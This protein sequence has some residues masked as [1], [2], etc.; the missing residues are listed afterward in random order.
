MKVKELITTINSIKSIK[1]TLEHLDFELG[2]LDSE[3]N[4][5]DIRKINQKY[6]KLKEELKRLENLDI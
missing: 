4:L 3:E 5:E 6:Q 1:D 2:C